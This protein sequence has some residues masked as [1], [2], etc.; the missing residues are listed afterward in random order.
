MVTIS[1]ANAPRFTFKVG[2]TE[3]LVVEFNLE[4]RISAPF[5]A[6]LQL[7]SEDEISFDKMVGQI[8]LLTM[9]SGDHDRYLHGV[10]CRFVQNGINGRFFLY[11][12]QVVP[13][14]QLLSLEQDCRIFQQKK[15]P[16]IVKAILEES[17]LTADLFAFRLQGSYA[18][19]DY[20]V[21]YRESDLNFISRLLE[22]EGIFYFFEHSKD[23]H[24]LVFGDGTVNYQPIG[25]QAKVAFNPGGGL[26]AEEEAVLSFHLA[27]Q[28]RTGKYTLRDFNFEKPSLDL[29]ADSSDKE[30]KKRECYDYPGE[31]DATPEGQ[32]LAQVRL[33][34]S[35]LFKE[36]AEGRSVVPRLAPGF[37]FTLSG[38]DLTRFNQEYLLTDIVHAG[39]QPQVLGEKAGSAGT[40]YENSF[41]AI[42]ATVTMRPEVKTPKPIMEGVQTAIVTGP[43]GEEIYTDKHGRVK[44]QFHWDRLGLK[45]DKSSCWIRVSQ[46]WAGAGWGA[47]FI[48]RIG[49]E[50]I[51]DFIEGDPDRPIITGRVYH[52]GNMP[53]YGLPGEK[54]KSTIKSNSS[55]GGGGSNEIRFEDKKG[56][57]EIYIHGQKD[58]TIAINDNKN[59]TIGANETLSVGS[60]RTKSVGG[61]QS[62]SIGNNK[63]IIVG[64]NHTE[65]IGANESITIGGSKSE[66]V[67]AASMENIGA[68]KALNVGGAYQ[69]SVGGHMN[70]TVAAAKTEQIGAAHSLVIGGV[71]TIAVG[72]SVAESIGGSHTCAVG[73]TFNLK[74]QAVHITAESEI[75]LKAGGA[76]ITLKGSDV[77]ISGTNISAKASGNV[78]LKG[79]TIKE[80]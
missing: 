56:G 2:K 12:A 67:A 31:Y 41:V 4:E 75:V 38:H 27:H 33:Q 79:S 32:R 78:T 34:Q 11:S 50:V 43:K 49:Q 80:N 70:E 63:T 16:D 47:M 6:E 54:T 59:Q 65:T 71:M 74:A 76:K 58:W 13:Q 1:Q 14:F 7:A 3:L 46:L 62:E 21:Q 40:R 57:E 29:T 23:K 64:A 36:R 22:E 39:A 20:C 73:G 25:G 55:T 30:N 77:T 17:G 5:C 44:V 10:I 37:T 26:V 42:P 18:Q 72:G 61:D 24:L 48:P 45:D 52:G 35:I 51:V 53:P 69:V 66:A 19:R 28:I 8:G 68:V 9:E 15:V 60:N